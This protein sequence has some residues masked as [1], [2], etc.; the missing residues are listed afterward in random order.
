MHSGVLCQFLI[1]LPT[2]LFSQGKW[3][4]GNLIKEEGKGRGMRVNERSGGS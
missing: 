3:I 1:E 2:D 4:D